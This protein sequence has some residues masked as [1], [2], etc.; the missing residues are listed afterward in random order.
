MPPTYEMAHPRIAAHYADINTDKQSFVRRVSDFGAVFRW[1]RENGKRGTHVVCR[2]SGKRQLCLEKLRRV[3]PPGRK[4]LCRPKK[5]CVYVCVCVCVRL[6]AAGKWGENLRARR[7]TLLQQRKSLFPLTLGIIRLPLAVGWH[8]DTQTFIHNSHCGKQKVTARYFFK[9]L[10]VC[11]D[12][13]F[14]LKGFVIIS[15]THFHANALLMRRIS[16][17]GATDLCGTLN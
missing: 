16:F 1:R 13:K 2:L 3:Q 17:G 9:N 15:L 11:T 5:V 14:V 7:E 6:K 4:D 8:T 10:P 12:H